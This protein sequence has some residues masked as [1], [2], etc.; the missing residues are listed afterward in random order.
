MNAVEYKKVQQMGQ[1]GWYGNSL[2]DGWSR[3]WIHVGAKS[4]HAH[5]E[6]TLGPFSIMY[7]GFYPGLR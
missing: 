3:D 1:C 5:P 4:F 7:S 6:W 2:W